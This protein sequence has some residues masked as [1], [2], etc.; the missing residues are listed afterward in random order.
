MW[1]A[2]GFGK[3]YLT[4]KRL[5]DWRIEVEVTGPNCTS[6]EVYI[7]KD[8]GSRTTCTLQ[9][10]KVDQHPAYTQIDGIL[11]LNLCVARGAETL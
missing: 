5:S 6:H 9:S 11:T 3:H 1:N 10:A 4:F 8:A 7:V 2:T